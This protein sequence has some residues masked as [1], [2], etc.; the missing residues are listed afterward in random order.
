MKQLTEY[1]EPDGHAYDNP[2]LDSLD[3]MKAVMHDQRLP[4]SIRLDAASKLAPYEHPIPKPVQKRDPLT[5]RI[6]EIKQ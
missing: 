4:T 1:I 5:V 2:T 3:F 6:P